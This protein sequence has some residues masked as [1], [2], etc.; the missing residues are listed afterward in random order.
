MMNGLKYI[1][2]RYTEEEMRVVVE[3]FK[4]R[5][6]ELETFMAAQKQ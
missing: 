4:Q 2:P 1:T 5:I 3:P 6:T